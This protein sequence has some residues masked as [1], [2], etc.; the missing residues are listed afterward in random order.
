MQQETEIFTSADASIFAEMDI[1]YSNDEELT[2]PHFAGKS[3][4]MIG[5]LGDDIVISSVWRNSGKASGDVVFHRRNAFRICGAIDG[6]LA[7]DKP[8]DGPA[9]IE[10]GKDK[11]TVSFSSSWPHNTIAPIER[12]QVGNRRNYML[13]GLESHIV[14]VSLPPSQAS[15]FAD[16]LRQVLQD[17]S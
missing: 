16:L 14:E 12:V 4:L 8:W 5:F 7:S 2:V 1:E 10:E 9:A 11:L 6:L 15:R 17:R 3:K 13:D